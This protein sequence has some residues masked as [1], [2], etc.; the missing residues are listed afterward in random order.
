MTATLTSIDI[1]NRFVPLTSRLGQRLVF[2]AAIDVCNLHLFNETIDIHQ[3]LPVQCPE[4][5]TYRHKH[6]QIQAHPMDNNDLVRRIRYIF[7]FGDKHLVDIFAL[8]GAT[9]T[10]SELEGWLTKEDEEGYVP[11]RDKQLAYFL[12][13]LII[14]NRGLKGDTLPKAESSLTN[15]MVLMKLKIALD[16]KSDDFMEIMKL[17]DLRVSKHEISAL[18]RKP[19]HKHYRACMDQ[20]LRNFLI[21]LTHK[22]RPDS[23]P[24]EATEEE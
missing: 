18:F 14:K 8:A 5:H 6:T 12:N 23:K 4:N 1:E 2:T 10:K 3:P 13:G 15:N 16:I 21:G 11:F 19:G 20:F 24:S 17:A 9:V 22:H 7:D